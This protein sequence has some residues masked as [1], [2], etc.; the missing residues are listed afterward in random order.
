MSI[1]NHGIFQW[2]AFQLKILEFQLSGHLL[3]SFFLQLIIPSLV[4]LLEKGADVI[5]GFGF[6]IEDFLVF[7]DLFE[8]KR[9]KAIEISHDLCIESVEEGQMTQ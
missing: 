5:A 9:E 1:R 3:K 4:H 7:L 2:R 8:E 6:F